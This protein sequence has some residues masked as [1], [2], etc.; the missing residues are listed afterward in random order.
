MN[1]RLHWTPFFDD[2][3]RDVPA[4]IR[5]VIQEGTVVGRTEVE[6]V[7][8]VG[9]PRLETAKALAAG[10]TPLRYLVIVA[11]DSSNDSIAGNVYSAI[12][13]CADG[14]VVELE[15]CEVSPDTELPT[16]EGNLQ[17]AQSEGGLLWATDP[18]FFV[19]RSRYRIG[20]VLRF[21][22][23][24]VA[25]TMKKAKDSVLETDRP[26]LVEAQRRRMKLL[27]PAAETDKITSVRVYLRGSRMLLPDPDDPW[28]GST[29][30]GPVEA[31]QTFELDGMEIVG[32]SVGVK[33]GHLQPLTA[34]IFVPAA[35][36]GGYRPKVG[37]E[38][39][40]AVW[41]QAYPSDRTG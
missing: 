15:V 23:A 28:R 20:D 3:Q 5:R 14:E 40:G 32:C 25:Y 21:R 19:N 18:F 26:E 22:V 16:L 7:D 17:L 34:R 39:E 35:K 11:T 24:G 12:P 30:R 38:V 33:G 36:L 27:D 2:P 10:A 8:S 29:F 1:H 4:V 41:L 37:D 6:L 13:F 9:I 31:V